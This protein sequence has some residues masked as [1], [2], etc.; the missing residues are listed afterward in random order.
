MRKRMVPDAHCL[1]NKNNSQQHMRVHTVVPYLFLRTCTERPIYPSSWRHSPLSWKVSSQWY[2]QAISAIIIG[3]NLDHIHLTSAP[4]WNRG[5]SMIS[6]DDEAIQFQL[7]VCSVRL[8]IQPTVDHRNCRNINYY[9]ALV[10]FGEC[11]RCVQYVLPWMKR[12][13]ILYYDHALTL[14]M[15]IQR[16]WIRSSFTWATF[17]FF[18]NRYLAFLG[19]IP[20]IV[21]SFWD[22][23]DLSHKFTVSIYS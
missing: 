16:F 19:H 20:V 13:V 23:S 9:T 7:Y 12:L 14:H 6:P 3:A 5:R 2:P 18:L 11:L 15:E 22:P 10:S 1:R 17:F 21:Q 8:D 4:S